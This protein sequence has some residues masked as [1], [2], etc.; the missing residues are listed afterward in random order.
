MLPG[1]W[2]VPSA[3]IEP[4]YEANSVP[5]TG[6]LGWEMARG[7]EPIFGGTRYFSSDGDPAIFMSITL[8]AIIPIPLSLLKY[9]NDPVGEFV[10]PYSTLTMKGVRPGYLRKTLIVEYEYTLRID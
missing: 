7:T 2:V 3:L 5:R 1:R 8:H 10:R 9:N 4:L 6:S